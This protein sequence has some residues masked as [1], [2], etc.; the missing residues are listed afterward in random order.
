MNPPGERDALFVLSRAALLDALAALEEHR[1]SVIVVG[2]QA[3]YL[4]AGAARVAVAE[5]TKD[6]DLG[7]DTRTLG[8][9]PLIEDALRRGG[10]EL[11]PIAK[12]PGAW[13][14]PKGIP[15]DL[16]VAAAAVS[17][18]RAAQ[19]PARRQGNASGRRT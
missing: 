17:G 18:N 1:D 3:V 6:S 11:D 4:R 7:I 9:S 14:S 15:L 8:D 5:A 13:M 19:V 10:F 12:Q 16:L 2:A